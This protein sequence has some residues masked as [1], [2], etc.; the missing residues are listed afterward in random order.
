MLTGTKAKWLLCLAVMAV[1]VMIGFLLLGL[2]GA[3]QAHTEGK[4][5]LAAVPA[6]PYQ[7][8]AWTSPDPARV[9]ELH[10]ATTVLLAEDASPVLDANVIVE[11]EP[12]Q[13]SAP[14]L[15][16]A[17]TTADSSNKFLY[18]AVFETEDDGFYQILITVTGVNGAEGQASF[19][20]EILPAPGF[21]WLYLLPVGL[22]LAAVVLL[23]LA[24]RTP[25]HPRLV[26][27]SESA[28]DE[29]G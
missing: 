25:T 4:M 28:T 19:D 27:E 18:E 5:Q 23:W 26:H 8:T 16:S 6:G 9:G 2:P 1:L 12:Q 24:R 3:V 17:A 22:A 13:G 7:L 14:A 20:L 29:T 21:N 11:V 15:S 10:V